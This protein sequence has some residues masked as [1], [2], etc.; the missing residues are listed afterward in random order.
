M[1]T[2]DSYILL[3]IRV[4]KHIAAW[5]G[6]QL[7][8]LPAAL[9]TG[10]LAEGKATIRVLS[11]LSKILSGGASGVYP[12]NVMISVTDGTGVGP[13]RSIACTQANA[14][15]DTLTLTY[16]TLTSVLT[17]G[18]AGPN[19]FDRGASNA[20]T[21]INLAARINTHPIW[22]SAFVATIGV[23]GTVTITGKVPGTAVQTLNITTNDATAFAIAAFTPGTD[24]TAAFLPQQ[25]WV[26]KKA[27][28]A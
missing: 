13:T 2:G 15:G 12:I 4:H 26:N 18:A 3:S 17:E 1:P 21:A 6:D 27:V 11:K 23:A 22:G 20:E 8:P 25:V 28:G 7:Y 16:G 19:G 10:Q 9:N 24:G 14:A 5:V